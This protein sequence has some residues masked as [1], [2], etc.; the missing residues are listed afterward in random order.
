[1]CKFHL[2]V[3]QLDSGSKSSFKYLVCRIAGK[4]VAVPTVAIYHP[5]YS[6][7]NNNTNAKFIDAFTEYLVESIMMYNDIVILGDFNLHINDQ[8]D[9][10]IWHLY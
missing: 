6:V 7:T 8:D 9:S 3:K 10:D 2:Q 4:S 5:L 1:M